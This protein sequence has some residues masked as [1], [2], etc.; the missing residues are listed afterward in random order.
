MIRNTENELIYYWEYDE[1]PSK[2]SRS[3]IIREEIYN[4]KEK[5]QKEKA[6]NLIAKFAIGK[7][8]NV[9]TI[10]ST[11]PQLYEL[12]DD[13]II[14][15]MCNV[16]GNTFVVLRVCRCNSGKLSQNDINMAS[17]NAR[18]ALARKEEIIEYA[19]SLRESVE[20]ERETG[21]RR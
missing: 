18:K 20:E 17:D 2:K 21:Y 7:E 5:D 16:A 12:Y 1:D 6:I 15:L 9:K 19:K 11:D 14:V 4:I 3:N 8:R 10:G 13:N